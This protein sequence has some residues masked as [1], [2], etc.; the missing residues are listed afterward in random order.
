MGYVEQGETLIKLH[1]FTDGRRLFG[2]SGYWACTVW[3]NPLQ[4]SATVHVF[5]DVP[6]QQQAMARWVSEQLAHAVVKDETNA[7]Q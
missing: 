1:R 7:D 6:V 3:N 2:T 5:N 4:E